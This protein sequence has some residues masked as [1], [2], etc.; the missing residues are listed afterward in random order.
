LTSPNKQPAISLESGYLGEDRILGL[1]C[2]AISYFRRDAALIGFLFL[3]I[4]VSVILNLLYAW[5][6]AI[7]VD[8]VLNVT[9]H[10]NWIHKLLLAPFGES[11]IA[12]VLGMAFLE[13]LIKILQET[14]WMVRLMLSSQIKCNG[15]ARVRTELYEKL[16][17]LSLSWYR[18]RSQGDTIYRLSYDSLGPWGIL[19]TFI[20]SVAATVTLVGMLVI[21]L[22]RSVPLTLFALSITPFLIAANLYFSPKIRD[23][24]AESKRTDANFTTTAQHALA[25]MP[26]IQAFGR[27]EQEADRFKNAVTQSVTA[28]M[29]LSWQENLYP[30][31]IQVIFALG[32]AVI[33]GYGGWLVYHDQFLHPVAG[34]VTCGDLIVFMTYLGQLW[35]PLGW[36]LGFTTKIQTYVASCERVLEIIAEKPS[37]VDEPSAALLPVKPRTLTLTEVSFGYRPETM[38][39]RGISARIEPGEMVAFLGA[40]G[41]GKSTLLNLIPRFYDPTGGVIQLDNYNIRSVRLSDLRKHIALVSQESTLFPDTILENLRYG[42]E[43]ISFEKIEAAVREA[44]ASEFIE[45]LPNG[46][47][48]EIIEGGQNLSGG[49]RQRLAIAR[50][51]LT[52][53]P[54]LVLDEP[55]SALDPAHEQWV[56]ETLQRIRGTRTVIIVTHRLE[57]VQSCDRIFVLQHGFIAESGTHA[58]LVARQGVYA[59]ILQPAIAHGAC[60]LHQR[61]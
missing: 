22:L 15:T 52:D 37:V 23:R 61:A 54:I 29:Q 56:M 38:I 42:C 35:E 50:A 18:T 9:P 36:V 48:T 3:M 41:T 14:V 11:K 40:S 20:G 31:A 8:T 13:M 19:D 59:Q 27:Q 49:Q 30:L 21:M 6:I 47:E 39:L 25:A 12:Q 24:A 17:N 7:L 51:L 32:K 16:Q 10:E 44:G 43:E 33:F 46:Y 53:A 2:W 1:I 45:M 60:R 34:G 57:T 28:S 55:T 5:P 26:L 4:G 58:D